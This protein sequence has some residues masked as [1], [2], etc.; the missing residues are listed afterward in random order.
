MDALKCQY[1]SSGSRQPLAR[2]PQVASGLNVFALEMSLRYG[3]IA[4]AMYG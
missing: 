1:I 2:L 3:N 4:A